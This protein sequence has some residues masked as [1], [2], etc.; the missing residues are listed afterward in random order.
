MGRA[1]SPSVFL[2]PFVSLSL[3][4]CP[5]PSQFLTS[6]LCPCLFPFL[7]LGLKALL[8]TTLIYIIGMPNLL[9]QPLAKD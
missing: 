3:S 9:N 1:E 6:H 8:D 7:T 2:R 4:L 5:F